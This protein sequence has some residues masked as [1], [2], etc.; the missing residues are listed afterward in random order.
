MLPH[1]QQDTGNREDLKLN[2]IAAYKHTT[3]YIIHNKLLLDD[4]CWKLCL[5]SGIY[6]VLEFFTTEVQEPI[7]AKINQN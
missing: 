6:L 7:L 4:L 3:I 1:Y 2:L 5:K